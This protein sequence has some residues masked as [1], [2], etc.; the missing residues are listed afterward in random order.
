[1]DAIR[2]E[3]TTV[4]VTGADGFIGSH[5]V[6][7]LVKHGAAVTA[8]AQY[9]SF[10]TNGWL[11]EL[12]EKTRRAINIRRA[13]IRDRGHIADI[14]RNQEVIF[15]LAALISVP[16][17]FDSAQSFVDT[18]VLGTLNVL[19]AARSHAAK[20]IVCTSTS[21]VYGSAQ[22][23][24]ISEH[25]RLHAQ[26]PYAASKIG[27]DMM[28]QS[29][30]LTHGV[31]VVI[32][33]PF[34]TFGPRQSER[35]V[36]AN[37]IRQAVDPDCQD[38]RVGTLTTRRDFNYVGDIA[39]AFVKAGRSALE[40]GTPYNVGT[41]DAITIAELCEK[42]QRVTGTNKPVVTEKHRI[43]PDASEVLELVADSA[44]FRQ[45]SGWKPDVSFDEGLARTIAWWRESRAGNKV[46]RSSDYIV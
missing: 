31:P 1:M 27:A 20:R 38:I 45:A 46:R 39:A 22:T 7:A 35:A 18:N 36:I 24:P 9:N 23:V 34:N 12:P 6:E 42:V 13:D 30:A 21:E 37:V 28:A 14:A 32:L 43:R 4:L 44:A 41:G 15:H 3:K 10:G 8:V 16:H 17:S 11:D 5:L 40:I 26:S 2:Y 29:Y 19:E 33:R 25:H